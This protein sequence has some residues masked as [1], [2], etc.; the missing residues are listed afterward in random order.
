MPYDIDLSKTK[1]E[2]IRMLKEYIEYAMKGSSVLRPYKN[3]N[4]L[5]DTDEFCNGICKFLENKGYS[6]K[7][8]VGSS[9]YKID[10][11]VE[12]PNYPGCYVA[13][14]ECP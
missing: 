13:G 14:I 11:A 2:G 6:V 5:Y 3:P 4:A 7:Q 1:S 12:H 9:E 8:Y 10:I